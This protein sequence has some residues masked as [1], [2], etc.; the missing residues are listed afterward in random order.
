MVLDE[1]EWRYL[2][3][4]R[5]NSVR[6]QISLRHPHGHYY[7]SIADLRDVGWVYRINSAISAETFDEAVE[8]ARA[9]YQREIVT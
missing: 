5:G 8:A 1:Q 4:E 3:R 9:Y 7:V 6:V 2:V